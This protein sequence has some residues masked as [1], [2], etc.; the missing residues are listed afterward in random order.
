LSDNKSEYISISDANDLEINN[1]NNNNAKIYELVNDIEHNN[2]K[3]TYAALVKAQLVKDSL[4]KSVLE[5][6]LEPT[7]ESLPSVYNNNNNNNENGQQSPQL[8]TIN[9]DGFIGVERK[10]KINICFFLSGIANGVKEN[11]IYAYLTKR[12]IVP[13]SI[14]TFQSRRNGTMSAKICIPSTFAKSVLEENF[15]PKFVHCKFVIIALF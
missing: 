8:D 13:S 12:N 15:W 1:D 2:S 5:S 9:D 11:H 4:S 14:L 10:R 6:S 7:L 3:P